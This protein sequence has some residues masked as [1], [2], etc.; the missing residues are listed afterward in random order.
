MPLARLFRGLAAAL[1]TALR[2][3]RRGRSDRRVHPPGRHPAGRDN[4]RVRW[5]PLVLG[6]GAELDRAHHHR[7]RG[8]RPLRGQ[9]RG[10]AP[11]CQRAGS[12]HARAG[13]E[14]LVHTAGRRPDRAHDHPERR[15]DGVQRS[16][17]GQRARGDH[18][19]AGRRDLVHR[20]GGGQDRPDSGAPAGHF[21]GRDHDVPLVGRRPGRGS[22]TSPPA[23]TGR[24]GSP[25]ATAIASAAS[26][27]AG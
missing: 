15:G 8:H 16:E 12:D 4:G 17:R 6:G 22:A 13:R 9:R 23:Q 26:R 10:R 21:H 25:R 18:G 1:M 3:A 27:R 11:G 20:R 7:R 14:P 24:S 5:R 19:R 2:H